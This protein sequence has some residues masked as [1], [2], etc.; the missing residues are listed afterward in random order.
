MHS[1]QKGFKHAV[2]GR[3][4]YKMNFKEASD[5]E[6]RGNS[7]SLLAMRR[8]TRSQLREGDPPWE[9]RLWE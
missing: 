5:E 2:T 4:V 7:Y 8:T 1:I 3:P 9:G 6:E